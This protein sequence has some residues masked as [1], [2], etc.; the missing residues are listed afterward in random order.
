MKK[1][2]F[3]II[4]MIIFSLTGKTQFL[5]R[6]LDSIP[7]GSTQHWCGDSAK[8]HALN[9]AFSGIKWT[10]RNPN[11]INIFDST[12][13]VVKGSGKIQIDFFSNQGNRS[14]DLYLHPGNG[15][16][17]PLPKDSFICKLDPTG[18]V[19]DAKNTESAARY[20]WS[21]GVTTRTINPT[22]FG[23]Y[24]VKITDYCSV[25]Y[26]T[27]TLHYLNNN[28]PSIGLDDTIC[29]NTIVTLDPGLHSLWSSY[30]WS[31]G[32]TTDTLNVS[33]NG[34][35]WLQ[36]TDT[37][38]CTARDTI[39]LFFTQPYQGLQI[40][41]VTVDENTRRNRTFWEPL[42]QNVNADSVKI[43][44][45]IATNVYGLIGTVEKDSCSFIDTASRPQSKAYKYILKVKDTCLNLSKASN[46]H[47]TICLV[48]SNYNG[49]SVGFSWS[50][51]VGY[52]PPK[53]YIIGMDSNNNSTVLDSVIGTQTFYNWANPNA[54]D[55]YYVGF[56]KTCQHLIMEQR[57]IFIPDLVKSNP[58]AKKS[59][60]GIKEGQAQRVKIY[61]NPINTEF[62]VSGF[63]GE[64]VVINILGQT[65]WQDQINET[66][67]INTSTWQSGTY[68]VLLKNESG[69]SVQKIIK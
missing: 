38:G 6:Y 69:F 25:K 11:P 52:T 19:L 30:R 58:L 60:V 68:L 48:V 51:Y 40:C 49:T 44:V 9:V 2:I 8:I 66:T 4:T 24:W 55:Y 50:A 3:L 37:S 18:I 33:S 14:F 5:Q 36:V 61:P 54:Y 34:T 17:D 39:S 64:I 16:Y 21:T 65:I 28:K 32:A 1:I 43:Y 29:G 20:L 10:I 67:T 7:N 41:K 26:D 46:P 47:Q 27:I 35:Y 62:R 31:T 15:P 63:S 45:E 56:A 57:G 12:S 59:F 42:P 53:Y 13:V 22:I 23:T